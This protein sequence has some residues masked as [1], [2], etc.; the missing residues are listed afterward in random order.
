MVVTVV[1]AYICAE[2]VIVV[3]VKVIPAGTV[4]A[5]VLDPPEVEVPTDGVVPVAMLKLNVGPAAPLMV[6]VALVGV[7]A[8]MTVP[9]ADTDVTTCP[10]EQAE[11]VY[12]VTC[13]VESAT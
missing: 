13:P 4:K 3:V 1:E 5:T 2:Y 9:V 12:A 11:P 10:A 7:E 6:V 8:Q